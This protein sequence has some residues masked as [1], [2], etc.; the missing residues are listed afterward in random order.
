[1][2]LG[3]GPKFSRIA[4]GLCLFL[5][6]G[7]LWY[8]FGPWEILAISISLLVLFLLLAVL[9]PESSIVRRFAGRVARVLDVLRLADWLEDRFENFTRR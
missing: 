8:A 5:L 3:F 6:Y 1:M 7:V 4:A 2:D 9:L